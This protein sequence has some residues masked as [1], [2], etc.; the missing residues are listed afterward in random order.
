MNQE[1]K[2]AIIQ[3]FSAQKKLNQL[4][5]IHSP[6]Y[7]GDTARYLCHV[8]YDLE[9]P[10]QTQEA[11]QARNDGYDGMIGT[12]KVQVR[13]N[14]CPDGIPVRL[15]EPFG[16]DELIVVLAPNCFLRPEGFQNEFV[17]YR[18]TKEEALKK[19]KR[20][21]GKYIGGKTLFSEGYDKVL[22]LI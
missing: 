9:L 12:S 13:Y 4:G 19:F 6:D 14:N 5:I 18:F 10:K 7:L 1:T 22:S 20:P 21:G 16:F 15:V 11:F 17:F 8:M 2:E 3:F